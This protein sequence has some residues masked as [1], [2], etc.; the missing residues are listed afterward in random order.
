MEKIK[1]MIIGNNDNRIYEI[2]SLLGKDEIAFIGLS[3][4]EESALEK[5]L[6]LKP[7]II[8][9]QCD[10]DD[11]DEAVD[12][13]GKI[14]IKLPGCCVIFLCDDLDATI[15]EKAMLAGVRKVLRFPIDSKILTENI[16]L[17]YHVEKTRL[18]NTNTTLDNMQSRVITVFGAKGGIGKTTITANVAVKLTQMGKK[19]AI[20]DANLQ[21]GDVNVFFD[22]DSKNTIAD[23]SQGRDAADIDEIKRRM[24]LHYSGVSILCAPKSPEY[25][26]YVSAKNVETI[27]NTMRP[28]YDYILI[29]TAP[30]F[31]DVTM[32]AL[33][34]SN[35]ILM[36]SVPDIS[37]LRNT[38]IGLNILESLQQRDKTEI[39]INRVAN[40]IIT[41]KDIQRV[42]DIQVKNK[43]SFDYKIALNCHN[44]GIP[45]VIDSPKT[46]IAQELTKLAKSVVDLIDHK[47]N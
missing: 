14:Y 31:N 1:V 43:I 22:I 5:V 17:V 6:S 3:K 30:L 36:V 45:I 9:M 42:L 7:Q 24:A 40:G 33:E 32:A 26:E 41:I 27:I 23:L 25:G 28:Y 15:I 39:V 10:N 47:G 35:L 44:K 11:D 18:K 37:T 13:A 8:I 38:K 46:L 21:F 20:I 29:D 12:L 34:N 4:Q 16:M 19:V 2:K